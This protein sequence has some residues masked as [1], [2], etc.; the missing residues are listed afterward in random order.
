M[1]GFV[2]QLLGFF[3]GLGPFGPLAFG[4][5]DSSFLVLPFG[6]DL[7]VVLL[8]AQHREWFAVYAAAA[9]VGS[10]MGIF[11]LDIVSRTGGEEGL[12]KLVK[13]KRFDKLKSKLSQRSGM[14]L[15]LAC[16][17]PP[18]FPFTPVIAAASAFQ[19]PRSRLL[20]IVAA[21]RTIRF[22]ILASAALWIGDRVLRIMDSDVF[23]WSVFA[24]FAICIAGSA[25]SVISRLRSSGNSGSSKPVLTSR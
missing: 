8:V 2:Q 16:L 14:V 4:V 25:L 19:Y 7:L 21:G 3:M 18:P 5:L 23:V 17:A 24:L 15:F 11:I 12:R 9:A 22:F 6:N 13:P 1:N 10:V 20:C